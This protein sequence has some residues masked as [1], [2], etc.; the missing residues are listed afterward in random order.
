MKTCFH[1]KITKPVSD[2]NRN[3]TRPDGLQQACRACQKIYARKYAPKIAAVDK[4]HS[5]QCSSCETIIQR[6]FP[7]KNTLCRSCAQKIA[8]NVPSVHQVKSAKAKEQVIRQGGIPNARHFTTEMVKGSVNNN[9]KGGITIQRTAEYHTVDYTNWRRDVFTRDRFTCQHCGQVGH[10]LQA[11]HILPRSTHP[12]LV[13][14]LSNGVTLCKACHKKTDSYA[15]R[16]KR[17]R[18]T[19]T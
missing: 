2:F 16:A 17:L 6:H 14:E 18:K 3:R 10:S 4:T 7:R 8:Q 13:Y 1:C 9:W 19:S 11:H 12:H 5:I 15:A